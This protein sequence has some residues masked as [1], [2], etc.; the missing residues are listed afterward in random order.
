MVEVNI[1]ITWSQGYLL[2]MC[3][4][5]EAIWCS[6]IFYFAFFFFMCLSVY[7]CKSFGLLVFFHRSKKPSMYILH[8]NS[9]LMHFIKQFLGTLSIIQF[10]IDFDHD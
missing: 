7:L 3:H 8:G 6:V 5:T 1:D 2:G 10:R 4:R 9:S